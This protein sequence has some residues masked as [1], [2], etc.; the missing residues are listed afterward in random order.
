MTLIT[1]VCQVVRAVVYP[2]ESSSMA[3]VTFWTPKLGP[4]GDATVERNELD[5]FRE[6]WHA[7]HDGPEAGCYSM[8]SG[9][10]RLP[11]GLRSSRTKWNS[12]G[13][14]K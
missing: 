9:A 3:T 12:R 7:R 1:A 13:A 2:H 10:S 5:A 14:T 8:R 11:I 6:R 4:F